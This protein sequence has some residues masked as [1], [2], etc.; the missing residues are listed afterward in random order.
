LIDYIPSTNEDFK[1]VKKEI[2]HKAVLKV[3]KNFIMNAL[4]KN[5]WNVTRAAQKVGLQ[6]SNLQA[7][8]KKHNIKL[9]R[10]GQSN[11]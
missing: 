8:M 5:D 3:E 9:P 2:R 4:T 6:R 11:P 7:L 1:R 10:Y